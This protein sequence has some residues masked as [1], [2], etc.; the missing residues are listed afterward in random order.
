MA[1]DTH[2]MDEDRYV[3]DRFMSILETSQ[4]GF[5]KKLVVGVSLDH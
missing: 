5:D 1:L 4:Y 2:R 3:S